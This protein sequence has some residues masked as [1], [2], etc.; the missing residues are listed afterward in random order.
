MIVG[1]QAFVIVIALLSIAA[2]GGMG[3]DEPGST[4]DGPDWRRPEPR[5]PPPEP[6]VSWPDFEQQFAEHVEAMRAR[7]KV[8]AA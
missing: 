4:D 5:R 7:D 1:F 6:H 3:G 8:P 2:G